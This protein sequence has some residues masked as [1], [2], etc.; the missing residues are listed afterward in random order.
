ADALDYAHD[1]GVIHRDLKP[2]NVKVTPDGIVK[3][4]D[5]G[6]AKALAPET[7]TANSA[8]SPTLTM[9]ATV[10]GMIMG[11]AGYMS[12]EQAKGKIV[13]RRADIWAF[14]V[15]LWEMLTGHPLFD[16]ETMAECLAQVLTKEP[17]W[18]TI[19]VQVRRLLRSCLQKDPRQRLKAIGD[20]QLLLE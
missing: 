19:P 10:A 17:A 5:F 9:R 7:K 20:W 11:T 13:D 2:A 18:E 4:L 16:A 1:K 15:V 6:L 3:V 14:G 8:S 12:P